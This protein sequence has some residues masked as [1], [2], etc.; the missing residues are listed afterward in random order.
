MAATQ[1]AIQMQILRALLENC[2]KPAVE[3]SIEET[4]FT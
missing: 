3:R 2:K 4:F 1:P